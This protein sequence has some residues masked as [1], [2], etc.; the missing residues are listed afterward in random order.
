MKKQPIA[1]TLAAAMLAATLSTVYADEPDDNQRNRQY[2]GT[3][4]GAVAGG[5][6][7]GPVGLL[8]GGLIGNLAGRHDAGLVQQQAESDPPGSA[9]AHS[10]VPAD[11]NVAA[12]PDLDEPIVVS[13]SADIEPSNEAGEDPASALREIVLN[14]LGLDVL[15]LTGS[16]SIEPLYKP[17]LQAIV[18]VMHRLP[19]IEVA[20]DGFSDRR[21]DRDANLALS[22]D[23]L[24][25]V[26]D[27]LIQAGIDESRIHVNPMGEQQFA[28][29]PGDL[30]AYAFDRRVAIRFIQPTQPATPQVAEIET[31]PAI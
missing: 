6:L 23:R 11:F 20:L 1:I 26:R 22:G 9:P 19:A 15:F 24:A 27:W 4:I 30:E 12:G 8:A 14:E 16:T 17:R 3:G 18:N 5:F 29:R 13:R 10:P 7:A 28:S 2:I 25:S 31:G 21:G